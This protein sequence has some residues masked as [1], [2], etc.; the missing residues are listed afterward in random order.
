[1]IRPFYHYCTIGEDTEIAISSSNEQ[2]ESIIRVE[3]P[4]EE[5]GFKELEVLSTDF[6]VKKNTGFQDLEA[7]KYLQFIKKNL[8]L[9]FNVV[10]ENESKKVG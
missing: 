7:I 3:E 9:M 4:D 5:A 6:S 10:Y 1:M 8:F 2:G